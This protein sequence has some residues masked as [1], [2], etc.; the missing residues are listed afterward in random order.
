MMLLFAPLFNHL[1]LLPAG[2]EIIIP[3]PTDLYQHLHNIIASAAYL[4]I[5]IRVSPTILHIAHLVPGTPYLPDE[6]TSVHEGSWTLSKV[7]VQENWKKEHARLELERA[8]AEGYKDGY[9]RAGRLDSKSGQQA[10]SRYETAQQD[11]ANHKPP[12]YTHRAC[13]KIAVW[14]ITRRYWAGNGKPGGEWDG[15]SVYTVTNAGAVFYQKNTDRAIDPLLEFVADKK[16]KIR[17]KVKKFRDAMTLLSLLFLGTLLISAYFI[18]LKEI[19]NWPNRAISST[20]DALRSRM[21]GGGEMAHWTHKA[22]GIGGSEWLSQARENLQGRVSVNLK[23]RYSKASDAAKSEAGRLYGEYKGK[24]S[25]ARN[26]VES[27]YSGAR[28]QAGSI[29]SSAT[30]KAGSKVSSFREKSARGRGD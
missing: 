18:S 23:E 21:E 5:C 26:K 14:P 7:V 29:Y 10:I 17:G 4:S 11:F 28:D 3:L 12:G 20:T 16:K 19:A 2:P 27:G 8:Q 6:H 15:Q 1:T 22:L 25:S 24:A 30:D 9:K 13:V